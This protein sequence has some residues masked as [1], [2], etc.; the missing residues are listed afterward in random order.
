MIPVRLALVLSWSL[1]WRVV[2][3]VVALLFGI[4]LGVLHPWLINW[5]A[6]PAEQQMG[7]P[8]D[9][10]APSTYVTRAITIDAP[11]S[12]VW[13]WIVQ[14][15]QDRA[16]FYSNT[17]LENLF[18][19]DIHNASGLHVEWQHR[20]LGDSVPLARPDLLFGLGAVGKA[21]RRP[22]RLLPYDSAAALSTGHAAV[23]PLAAGAAT[24]LLVAR[25]LL[26][27]RPGKIPKSSIGMVSKGGTARRTAP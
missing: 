4:S 9:A 2:L 12:A 11:P 16:G 7:L 17:W 20:A 19:S 6:T 8:G 21:R 18:G 1:R 26:A 25:T 13:P 10:A 14:M 3:P 15:G 23:P 22:D 24:L 27:P 5:G